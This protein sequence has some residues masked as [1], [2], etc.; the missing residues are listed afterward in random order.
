VL[1]GGSDDSPVVKEYHKI[2]GRYPFVSQFLDSRYA[3]V[4][5]FNKDFFS[6]TTTINRRRRALVVRPQGAAIHPPRAAVD[7]ALDWSTRALA[8]LETLHGQNGCDTQVGP[9]ANLLTIRFSLSYYCRQMHLSLC[10][11]PEMLVNAPWASS[12][13]RVRHRSDACDCP[14]GP[15]CA[16]GCVAAVSRSL[17]WSAPF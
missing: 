11:K 2:C 14:F 8:T 3:G 5:A 4:V 7:C 9:P 6:K 12:R 15:F 16:L 1:F 10:G 13:P 17:G